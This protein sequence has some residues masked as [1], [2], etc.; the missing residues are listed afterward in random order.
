[1]NRGTHLQVS[2]LRTI[3]FLEAISW[4]LL[5]FIAMPLKYMAGKPEMV[6]YVG[7]AHGLLFMLYILQ[8]LNVKRLTGWS[9]STVIVGCLASFL[10]FGTLFFDRRLRN[11]LQNHASENSDNN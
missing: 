1:M 11:Y 8:L 4:L 6:R 10:P 2:I 5:L 7:W 3:G 9:F